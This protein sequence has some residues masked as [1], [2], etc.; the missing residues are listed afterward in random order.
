MPNQRL[1]LVLLCISTIFASCKKS[2]QQPSHNTGKNLVLT[3]VEQQK[4]ITDNTF[5]FKLFNNLAAA[6]TGGGNLMISPLSISFA[7]G[8]TV[9]GASGQ[10]LTAIDS[11]MQFSGF[12]QDEL[13]T[14]Y[15]KLITD[16]P[17]LDPNTTLSIA[18]SI[19]YKQG[20]DV[21][22]AFISADSNYYK[23]EVHALDFASPTAP[24]LINNW[25]SSHTNGKIPTIVNSIPADQVMYLI[26]ALYF[27]STWL[28]SF[29]PNNTKQ[30]PFYLTGAP[31]VSTD[32][33]TATVDINSYYDQK[34]T[35][36]EM[37]YSNK[38]YSMVIVLPQKGETLNDVI[39]T[40]N[41]SQ[42]QTWM[43]SLKPDKE[44][45]FIPKFKFSY[46]AD[47][48]DALT[49][50]G[51]GVAFSDAAD[52]SRL[53]TARVKI[54]EVKHKT[55]IAVDETGTEAAA[56]T[57]V[58]VVATAAPS[59]NPNFVVDHP[60]VFAIREMNSGLILFSGI[61]N[62]PTLAGDN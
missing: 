37:P 16:L 55:F 25:V 39:P 49:A 50:M 53:T 47:L 34:V 38:K 52:F 6:N 8:M 44:P 48:K 9:N 41:Q 54:S 2:G 19:W 7:M 5:N 51:M 40:L 46:S 14:Y 21:L 13:N 17:Q 43:S 36:F 59:V 42:W 32:F 24:Q 31:S 22:P 29:D 45:V 28:E 20:F 27:K 3:A 23:A 62:N 33:M 57:S 12:T 1:I 60:F 18:N 26:N 56:V 30:Q 61:V 35:V 4:A 11:A 10:T 15:N 58:G